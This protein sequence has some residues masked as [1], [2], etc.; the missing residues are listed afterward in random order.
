MTDPHIIVA[1]FFACVA[2]MLVAYL[3]ACGVNALISYFFPNNDQN[4]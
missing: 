1:R 2:L 3:L 4:K